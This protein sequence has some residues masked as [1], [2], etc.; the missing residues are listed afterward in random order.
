MKSILFNIT[1]WHVDEQVPNSVAI[2]KTVKGF[3]GED[4]LSW[5]LGDWNWNWTT[6]TSKKE[7]KP[8]TDYIFTFWLNGGENDRSDE[9]CYLEIFGD[10]WDQ[11][12]TY[13]LNRDFILPTLIKNGWYLFSIPF[14][15]GS[16]LK[17]TM[18]FGVSGAVA[19]IA[20]AKEVVEYED[21]E[22]DDDNYDKPQRSNVVFDKGWPDD[23][24][25]RTFFDVMKEKMAPHKKKIVN[26]VKIA[27][28]VLAVIVIFKKIFKK[29]KKK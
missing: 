12:S 18:R 5:Q 7:L 22:G 6:L 13:K 16:E 1:D 9:V 19:T 10:D 3:D 15:T 2:I 26:S 20:P 23:I 11:R 25:N 17:T 4:V 8:N 14:T 21:L 29:K 24:K 28:T 27:G